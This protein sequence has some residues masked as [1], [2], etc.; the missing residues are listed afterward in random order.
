M[1][2]LVNTV[3]NMKQD[4][5][6]S[7]KP[8]PADLAAAE[9]LR[10]AWLNRPAGLTQDKMG[11]LLGI[12]QGGVSHYLHGRN[13]LNFRALMIFADALSIDPATIRTDLPEQALTSPSPSQPAGLDL[14][15]L[16]IA[17]VA[18]RKAIEA[19]EVSIDLY[20]TA[21]LIALAYRER[22]TLPA[23]PTSAQLKEFD[24]RII[25]RLELG[26]SNGEWGEGRAAG[27]SKKGAASGAT[28]KAA[29]RN[30]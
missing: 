27:T 4:K 22:S 16:Q 28:K 9:R 7:S 19:A 21:P 2:R 3:R 13:A 20:S 23:K 26:V 30:R 14:D 25:E 24:K 1:N 5:I 8:S 6:R 18:V 29:H 11:E 15:T 10:A 17:L 12:S